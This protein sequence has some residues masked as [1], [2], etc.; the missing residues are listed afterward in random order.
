MGIAIYAS[1][2]GCGRPPKE[3]YEASQ[4]NA[5]LIYGQAKASSKGMAYRPQ[6]LFL[7]LVPRL[8]TGY[9]ESLKGTI[10]V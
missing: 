4:I 2:M 6:V 5:K 9:E 7:P 10:A 8:G 3:Q 1:T